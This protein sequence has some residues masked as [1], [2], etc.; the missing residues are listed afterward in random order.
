MTRTRAGLGLALILIVSAG[1][2][3]SPAQRQL[4][5]T[6]EIKEALERLNV[7]GTAL[8]IAAHPD[9]ENTALLAYLARGRN[10]R[11]AYLSL[12]RGEG[13]QNL[14]GSEQ[15]DLMGV[16]RTQELLAA[17]RIDGAEQYFTRAIDF[18][19]SKTAEETLAKWGKE[20][21]LGDVVWVI[22]KL[23]PDVIVLRFSGTSRDGHGHHQSSAILGEEAFRAAADP[24]QFP[25]QLEHVEPW[26]AKRLLWNVFSFRRGGFTNEGDMPERIDVDP[27]EYDPV[28]GFSYAEIAGMS[29]S[30][31]RSQGFGAAERKGS[32]RNSLVLVDGEPAAD[33]VMDG[34]DTTWAR[35]PGSEALSRLLARAEREFEPEK[36]VKILPLLLEARRELKKLKGPWVERKLSELDEVVA[37]VTGLWLDVT[38]DSYAATPGATVKL[39]V[40]ALNRSG[41]EVRLTGFKADGRRVELSERLVYNEPVEVE[42][43]EW[44]V[45]ADHAYSRPYW[46]DL[47]KRGSLYQIATPELLGE[48]ET[49]PELSATFQ[50]E[51]AGEQIEYQ[52]PVI[53]RWVDR[54]RGELTRPVAVVPPVAVRFA[55]SSL[56]F[57]G[58]GARRIEVEL[59]ANAD[60]VRGEVE[61]RIPDGWRVEPDRQAFSLARRAQRQVAA[62]EVAPRKEEAQGEAVAVAVVDGREIFSE[63]A[64]IDYDHIPPQTVTR[65]AE[66]RFVRVDAK[67]LARRIG[68]VMGAGDDVPRALR[69]LSAEVT[70]L[71]ETE[72]TRG[73]LSRYD[74]IV[75]GVRAHN[76]RADL[77]A[78]KHRLLDYVETG[79]TLVVQYNV[80][81]RR[82]PGGSSGP[83]ADLG[84]YPIEIGRGRVSVEE[85]PVTLLQ[86]DHPVLRTPNRVAQTDF[87]G[88]VQERGLYFASEWDE[89]YEPLFSL[90][91]PGEEP[92]KGSTLFARHGKGVYIYTGLSFFRQLPAGVPG[93]YR[94]FANFLSAGQLQ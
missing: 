33:D 27:G 44:Q 25:E 58:A 85:A 52:R 23:R 49:P 43:Q 8:M 76:V 67:N 48:A 7:L 53:F 86:A 1:A 6:A 39:N 24:R 60:N 94:L 21:V 28:L 34:V 29:R 45:A 88:W 14:I 54:V 57:A 55:E 47:P 80:A 91:D 92:L 66:A 71:D 75:T 11:T 87:E 64:I 37:L 13:G 38:A 63:V 84:P 41:A 69:Q 32:S 15:G 9:D 77:R 3:P 40:T 79:G 18:G 30:Q 36:P 42:G 10:Y 68:Y 73:D 20:E 5:G 12:T 16:I 82:S 50:V 61:L 56:V 74:A 51:I 59:S 93:A 2:I 78:N 62:F 19:Y 72:L 70:L 22:R 26:Q 46:L 81:D 35:V 89:R 4:S 31:H 65:R 83:L 17:R 90:H